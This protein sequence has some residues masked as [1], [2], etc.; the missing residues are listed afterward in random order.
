ML[1]KKPDGTFYHPDFTAVFDTPVEHFLDFI[2]TNDGKI[3][4]SCLLYSSIGV[5]EDRVFVV[6]DPVTGSISLLKICTE[7]RIVISST[8]TEKLLPVIIPDSTSWTASKE[9]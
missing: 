5:Y 6:L 3:I 9:S 8:R 4:V 7:L 1:F 2:P